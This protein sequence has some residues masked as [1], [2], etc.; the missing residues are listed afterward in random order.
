MIT[1]GRNDVVRIGLENADWQVQGFW[2]WAPLWNHS[3]ETGQGLQGIT[4]WMPA[5]VPGS[6]HVDL[7]REGWIG[8]PWYRMQSMQAEWVEH[9]WWIY[10]TRVEVPRLKPGQTAWLVFEGLDD[11]AWVYARTTCLGYHCGPFEPVEYDITRLCDTEDLLEIRVAFR[12]APNEMGQIGRTSATRTQKSRFGYKW[13]FGTR[14]VNLGIWD[15]VYIEVRN[16]VAVKE[17]RVTTD[18]RES[19]GVV[20]VE[21][22]ATTSD[23]DGMGSEITAQITCR[24]DEERLVAEVALSLDR[25]TLRATADLRVSQPKLWFPNGY[26]AQPLYTVE[27]RLLA[28]QQE[29]DIRRVRTGIRSLRYAVNDG[30]PEALAYTIVINGKRIY[31]K[32]VNITPLDHTYGSVTTEQYRW[33][34]QS[35]RDAHVNLVRV[36]GVG[37]IEKEAFY[38]WCDAYGILVWQEFIQ[39]SSGIDN[40]PSTDPEFVELLEHTAAAALTQKRNHVAMT[41]WGGGNELTREENVPVGYEDPVIARLQALVHR[42]DPQ[43]LFLPTS[44]SGPV[45]FVTDQP[46][47]GHDVHGQWEYLGNSRHYEFYSKN[48]ALLHSEF[49]AP[50]MSSLASL[51]KMLGPDALEMTTMSADATWR[52]HG[53][54]WDTVERDTALFGELPDLATW[55]DA[56]QWVQAEA[57]RFI[58]EANRRRK[59]VNSGSVV[60]QLNEPWPNISNTCLMDYFG[61]RKMAYHWVKNAFAATVATLKY[62]RLDVPVGQLFSAR[63]ALIADAAAGPV[64]VSVVVMNPLGEVIHRFQHRVRQVSADAAEDLGVLEFP[65]TQALRGLFM[66]RLQVVS[67]EDME[68]AKRGLNT[69][70][71]FFSTETVHPYTLAAQL[72]DVEISTQAQGDWTWDEK[73]DAYRRSYRVQNLGRHWALHVRGEEVTEAYWVHCDPNYVTLLAGESMTVSVS[74]QPIKAGGFLAPDS[75]WQSPASLPEMVSRSFG[76]STE[77]DQPNK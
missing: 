69:N 28:N 20:Q 22:A 56:S 13:D 52:W 39:T 4:G 3:L 11:A 74:A 51:K 40:L 15:S 14:L 42:L 10:R 2:P 65:V 25:K 60:W 19:E 26:G 46:G 21:V 59:F 50:G 48:D 45:E 37:I 5:K 55:I 68:S 44:A 41:L 43:R 38:D 57:L 27:V 9:R 54:W 7:W 31:A 29:R 70:D 12:E 16:Q 72:S 49:G 76:Q 36:N 47:V 1:R 71:Y 62:D 30:R 75:G 35:M 58:I 53:E 24:D 23:D 64:T 32:G 6:V 18:V 34:I 17:L 67:A 33:L 77:R 61:R 63:L 8:N 66:V 73:A